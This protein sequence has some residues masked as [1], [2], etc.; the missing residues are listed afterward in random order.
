M[1]PGTAAPRILIADKVSATCAD[2]LRAAGFEAE[3]RPGLGPKELIA[4]VADISGL[5]VRSDTQVTDEVMAAAPRLK[6][7]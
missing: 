3:Q 2:V 6:V 4:A 1:S 7:V 5:V